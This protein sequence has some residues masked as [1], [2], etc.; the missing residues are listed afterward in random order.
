LNPTHSILDLGCGTGNHAIPLAKRGYSVVGIDRS[1]E[2]L[3]C[4]RSKAGNQLSS[5]ISFQRGSIRSVDL[6]HTFDA[7]LMMFAVLGYQ[8]ENKDVLAALRTARRHLNPGGILIFDI[9]HGPAVLNL[10]PSERSKIIPTSEG[11]M[12]R[13]ASGSLDTELQTCTVNYQIWRIKEDRILSRAKESHH[14]RCFSRSNWISFSISPDSPG[15]HL[16]RSL[17]LKEKPMRT[18]GTRSSSHGPSKIT[19]SPS[20]YIETVLFPIKDR[21]AFFFNIAGRHSPKIQFSKMILS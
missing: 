1:E 5:N 15:F 13:L 3:A 17:K 14:M 16:V 20:S 7:T 8:T 21:R 11:E 2:M 18:H 19:S 12:V 9:W 10:R 6:G 4:L